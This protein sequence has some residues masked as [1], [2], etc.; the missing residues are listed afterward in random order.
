M[1]Q[2]LFIGRTNWSNYLQLQATRQMDKALHSLP[3][4]VQYCIQILVVVTFQ[5]HTIW[6]SFVSNQLPCYHNMFAIASPYPHDQKWKQK[7]RRNDLS[8]KS[9]PHKSLPSLLE[10]VGLLL[11]CEK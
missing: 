9:M 7:K 2:V 3:P 5:T 8:P 11:A 6:V 4:L 1:Y 10:V